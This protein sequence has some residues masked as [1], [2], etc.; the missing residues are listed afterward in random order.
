MSGGTATYMVVDPVF[1]WELRAL[2]MHA[3]TIG[4]TIS[5]TAQWIDGPNETESSQREFEVTVTDAQFTAPQ[6]FDM[7]DQDGNIIQIKLPEFGPVE[8]T[9][10][11]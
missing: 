8:F 2:L 9:L 7:R 11:I 10:Y 4:R 3:A 6:A 5:F 1:P